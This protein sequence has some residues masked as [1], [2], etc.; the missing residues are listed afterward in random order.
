MLDF[1]AINRAAIAALPCI[2]RRLFPQGKIDGADFCIGDIHGTPGQSL[3]ICLRG[4]KVGV[5]KDFATGE[6]GSDPVSLVA[7]YARVN[8][9]EGAALL[10]RML[11][12][13]NDR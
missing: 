6:G 2:L 12:I 5:W 8:Q 13:D 10:A 4:P 9:G 7:A 11:G 3:R 1:Q